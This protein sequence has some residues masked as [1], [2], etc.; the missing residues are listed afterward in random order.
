MKSILI[1]DDEM[2]ILN[3]MSKA[4]YS[5]CDYQGEVRTVL[6]GREAVLEYG[7]RY[8]DLCFLDIRLRDADGVHIMREIKEIAPETTIVLMSAC[9]KWKGI[10][11]IA[12]NKEALFIDKPFDFVQVK[13]IIK[14]VFEGNDEI[15]NKTGRRIGERRFERRSL[16]RLISFSVSGAD[17]L[18]L[19]G[20]IID[21]SST[22]V[23]M[24]TYYPLEK[25]QV[26]YIMN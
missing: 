6:S 2:V 7:L 21:I 9:N 16:S 11:K 14:K 20:S 26:L 18:N 5:L 13:K 3:A 23:G 1:V 17:L 25:G 8:Y 10:S 12:K 4:L 22:G 24:R 19:K 15:C